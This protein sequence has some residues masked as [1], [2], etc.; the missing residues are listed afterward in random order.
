MDKNGWRLITD[1][2]TK[3]YYRFGTIEFWYPTENR[4]DVGSFHEN[5]FFDSNTMFVELHGGT[6][7][8][9]VVPPT[10]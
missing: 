8:R 7:W 2:P 9:E 4:A 1:R 6:H 10:E 3:D 5:N